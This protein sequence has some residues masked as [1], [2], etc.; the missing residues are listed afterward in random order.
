M[1]FDSVGVA[2]G[3]AGPSEG[4]VDFPI[5]TASNLPRICTQFYFNKACQKPVRDY[6][7]YIF[8]LLKAM[9]LENDLKRKQSLI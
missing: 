7:R 9:Y 8:V 1:S 5:K 4:L 3:E 6:R 2:G